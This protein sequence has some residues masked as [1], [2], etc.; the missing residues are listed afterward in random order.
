MRIKPALLIGGNMAKSDTKRDF[1]GRPLRKGE[2]QRKSDLRYQ[3]TYTDPYGNRKYIYSKDLMELRRKEDELKRD[4]L[5][6]LDIYAAGR[7]TIDFTFNRY[8]STRSDLKGSTQANYWHTYDRYIKDNLGPK[9]VV[10]L[11]HSDILQ[12]YYYLLKEKKLSYNTLES[13]H[14]L[15]HPIFDLAVMDDIIR[16]NP[17]DKI[18]GKIAKREGVEI[19]P[20]KAL[21]VEEQRAF[22]EYV[23][24]SPI[25]YHW[26]PIFTVLFGTGMRIGE[27][28]GLRWEDIDLEKRRISVNHSLS[29]Y[30]D[31]KTGECRLRVSTP[32]TKAGIRTIP[33]MASVKDA[34]EVEKELQL[35]HKGLN[36]TVIDGMSGFIFQ[37][38]DG[39]CLTAADINRAIK[40]IYMDH[41]AEEIL[42][43]KKE[44]RDPIIIP[45]FTCHIC[46]HTF[47]TRLCEVEDNPKVI[48]SIMGHKSVVTTFDIYTDPSDRRNEKSFDKLVDRWND[49]F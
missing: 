19:I 22:K 31:R 40:R 3:Y 37:N 9:R 27:C 10:D 36:T 35:D 11:K 14:G 4:Q 39:G 29:Y 15:I 48:Q 13:V 34:F 44:K 46:R 49:A 32:K 7:A 21:T 16:R 17:S 1:R 6:G 45:H 28:I 2:L 38:R 24:N 47:A 20:K 8:M 43:A 18:M 12:F 25:Y 42:K 23:A 5:D 33:M 26:W 30:T 41:N